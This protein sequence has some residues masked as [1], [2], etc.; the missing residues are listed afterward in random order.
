MASYHSRVV[1]RRARAANVETLLLNRCEQLVCP[2]A[3]AAAA[4]AAVVVVVRRRP[5]PRLRV[6]ARVFVSDTRRVLDRGRS[7]KRCRTAVER[8]QQGREARGEV[9]GDLNI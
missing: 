7:L 2:A 8:H 9:L 4:A 1:E 5:A 3:A 6:V